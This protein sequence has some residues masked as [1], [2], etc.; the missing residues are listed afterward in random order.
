MYSEELSQARGVHN[1]L[2]A[3]SRVFATSGRVFVKS[4]K[5]YPFIFLTSSTMTG[6]A[7]KRSATIP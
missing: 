2:I 6:T 7:S 5:H 1:S 4:G 3:V